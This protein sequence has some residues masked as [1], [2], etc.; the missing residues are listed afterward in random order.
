[1]RTYRRLM[2]L[3]LG[4]FLVVSLVPEKAVASLIDVEITATMSCGCGLTPNSATVGPGVE[5]TILSGAV[6]FDFGSNSLEISAQDSRGFT[7]SSLTFS[8]LI[9]SDFPDAVIT[10]F[11]LVSELIPG[12]P[13]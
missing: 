8:G 3:I 13:K 12:L 6:L 2:G 4:F 9:W 11:T 5:F 7:V 1:M 10:E